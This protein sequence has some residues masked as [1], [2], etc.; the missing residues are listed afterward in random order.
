MARGTNLAQPTIDG[1][2]DALC[3]LGGTVQAARSSHTPEGLAA[4]AGS[5]RRPLAFPAGLRLTLSPTDLKEQ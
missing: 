3:I 1:C 4:G 2:D 5:R